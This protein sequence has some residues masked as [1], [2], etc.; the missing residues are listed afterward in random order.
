MDIR[1]ALVV[2]NKPLYELH[3]LEEKNSHYLKLY[4]GQ[5]PATRLW[6]QIYDEHHRTL[7]G[8]QKTLS[9]LGIPAQMVFRKNLK[10]IG[11][12]DLV[13]TVGG[14]GTFLE[15]SHLLKKQVLLGVNAA[16]FDSIGA[17]CRARLENFLTVLVDLIGGEIKPK[18]YAR[19]RIKLGKRYLPHLVLNETLFANHSP[20]GTSR[21]LVQLGKIKEEHKSSGVWIATATGSTAA[22]RSSGGKSLP[23]DRPGMQYAVREMF[24]QKGKKFKI[25]RG[26]LKA[27]SK[28]IFHSKMRTGALFID[29]NHIE[30][31]VNYGERIEISA[32]AP[33]LRAVM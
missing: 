1:K 19:L 31:P 29:G 11:D 23:A 15:T 30:V 14:D 22:I 9:L 6:K 12:Y 32:D 3:I 25:Q 16:P 4:R 24:P 21:Y 27:K 10:N 8:V 13:V 28:L 26:I 7:E 5:H 33:A 17:L 2:Y 20:A 18:K